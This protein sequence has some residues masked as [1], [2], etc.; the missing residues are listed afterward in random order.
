MLTSELTA[1]E[2]LRM[3]PGENIARM[4]IDLELADAE[5]YAS[6]TLDR[7]RV[8]LGTDLVVLGSYVTIGQRIRLD[9]RVQNTA[10]GE[11]SM[12]VSETGT[13]GELLDLV[14]R[15]GASLRERLGIGQLS[16]T[17]AGQLQATLPTN[18]AAARFYS[19]GRQPGRC[20][21]RPSTPIPSSRWRTRRSQLSGR[22]SATT[23]K[24]HWKPDARSTY[25]PGLG[26]RTACGWR[27]GIGN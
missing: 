7:I 14:S 10:D 23:S 19:E 9:L 26:G 16:S 25:R 11:A 5:S 20:S 15:T 8:N 21:K 2:Q 3:I 4:K 27:G 13:E 17:E 24:R 1:G 18:S 12:V 22:R 6:E